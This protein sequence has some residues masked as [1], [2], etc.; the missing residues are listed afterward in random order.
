MRKKSD[1]QIVIA[2][3]LFA[4]LFYSIGAARCLTADFTQWGYGTRSFV[5]ITW[6]LAILGVIALKILTRMTAIGIGLIIGLFV[7]SGFWGL[8]YHFILPRL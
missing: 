6:A 3:I 7:I 1:Y 8:V 4:V 2:A 5:F